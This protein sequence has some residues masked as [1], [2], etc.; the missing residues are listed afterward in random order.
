MYENFEQGTPG[1]SV[2]NITGWDSGLPEF[3]ITDTN[4]CNGDQSIRVLSPTGGVTF[5][6][7]PSQVVELG[8]AI[9]ISF[10]YKLIDMATG[11]LSSGNI[12]NIE[13]QYSVNG[14]QNWNV[15]DVIDQNDLP[16]SNCSVHTSTIPASALAPGD[17][18]SWRLRA[19]D[20]NTTSG[21]E[22][23]IYVDDF[24]AIED[25][26]CLKPINIEV[27]P[28]SVSFTSLDI[29]WVDLNSP[30][31]SE[32][33]VV[34]CTG[35][36][37]PGDSV[38]NGNPFCYSLGGGSDI[39]TVN[40]TPDPATNRMTATIPGLA[41]G[42]TYYIYVRTVCGPN[43]K[44]NWNNLDTPLQ[45]QTLAIGSYCEESIIINQDPLNPDNSVDLP[46]TSIDQ[47]DRF[48][49][50][51][52]SST[53]GAACGTNAPVLDGYEVVYNMVSSEDDI[54]TIDV[55]GLDSN[56]TAGVFVYDSCDDIGGSDGI[57]LYGDS[58]SDGSD[59]QLNSVFVDA[60]Q[61]IY[62]VIAT[63]DNTGGNPVNS[64][65]ELH[66][67]GFDCNTWGAPAGDSVIP[68]VGSANQTLSDF[69]NSIR[70]V[71]P[72]PHKG[73]S[74]SLQWYPDS[75][76][77]PDFS[78]P[79]SD[80]SSIIINDQDVF[81]VTQNI[82]SCES[83]P[84]AVTFDEITCNA[85][86]GGLSSPQGDEVCG[87]GSM[88]LS[89]VK[90]SSS[91]DNYSEV[92]WYNAASGGQRLGVGETFDT[93]PI[94]ETTSYWATEVFLGAG[95][96]PNQGIIGPV[97]SSSSSSDFGLSI[98]AIEPFT[99]SSVDVYALGSGNLVLE[100]VDESSSQLTLTK[101][102]TLNGGSSSVPVL[103][104]IN[105]DWEFQNA[106]DYYLRKVS[107][108]T[109]LYTSSSNANFPY[110]LGSSASITGGAN[111]SGGNS[112][113]YYYFYNWTIKGT[114][115]LCERTPRTEVEAIVHEI[116][117]I[118]ITAVEDIVCVGSMAEL[119]ASSTDTDYQYTW[120]WN[121]NTNHSETGTTITPTI[122]GNTTFTV[123]GYNPITTC[124]TTASFDIIANGV[125]DLGVIPVSTDV[126]SDDI[127]RLTAGSEIFDFEDGS[128][129]W[130]TENNSM[131]NI[132]NSSSADWE[133]VNSPFSPEGSPAVNLS[134][135][136]NSKYYISV[137]DQLGSGASLD[138]RLISPTVNLVGVASFDLNFE[139]FF[140]NYSYLS[141]T[142]TAINVEVSL[143]QGDNWESVATY[144]FDQLDPAGPFE[145]E[146]ISLD[147]YVGL[148]NVLISFHYTGTWGWWMAVDN[149]VFKRQFVE[150]FVTWSP[151]SD[152]YFDDQATIPYDGS[153]VNE[154]YFTQS[155]DGDYTYTALL[156]FDTCPNVSSNVDISV[157]YTDIPTTSS[158][159]Q[160]Y[161]SGDVVDD[162]DVT[163]TNLKFYLL[164][165]NG[166]YDLVTIN[167]LLSHGQ[168]YYVT[169][170]LN[171]CESDFLP[172]TVELDCPQ[173]TNLT[174]VDT[175]LSLDEDSA[176]IVIEWDEPAN[177]RSIQ[178]YIIEI[179]DDSSGQEVYSGIIE[180]GTNFEVINDLPIN[181]DLT[182]SMY[183]L[184]DPTIP[185]ESNVEVLNFDTKDLSVDN[186]KIFNKLVCYPNP[187][188]D[189]IYFENEFAI[190]VIEIYSLAGQ[191]ILTKKVGM[192][193]VMLS[194]ES[195]S[196]GVYF[197][198][199]YVK[200]TKQIIKIIK[201]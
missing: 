55:T 29:S 142:D 136:D 150:G 95:T 172:I 109:L 80:P 99:L 11:S 105:L 154:V 35:P 155:E 57:C 160:S 139:Y 134:S 87:S 190:D 198:S 114:Q 165:Q 183:S 149:V 117:P 152:L 94:S 50:E 76:G 34:A 135:N 179:T 16:T 129:G 54:L 40:G 166:E 103:T 137:A 13:L 44:S 187:T 86:L 64:P 197:A 182:L 65:Y 112:S 83:T 123:E 107:G 156:N 126:C 143:D 122:L 20:L 58:T 189:N 176:S 193:K 15:Y 47:T 97:T 61:E 108:P 8:N 59:I 27:D 157:S 67:E 173:P 201:E 110:S 77:S 164:D 69:T 78:N 46:Y 180:G 26:G 38:N 158:S 175:G 191:K 127:V 66:I 184:C 84:L 52:Y 36:G 188:K 128:Q 75:G 96:V 167:Y 138:T 19:Q 24:T 124:S 186:N 115:V 14:G 43:D 151:T 162:L 92:Y 116:Q 10:T 62:I 200:N 140:R 5:V 1:I 51:D 53:P 85:D 174:I 90:N 60:G 28:S 100:L 125:G 82:G 7:S 111:A 39:I 185:V 17:N 48:G 178:D 144:D 72:S 42:T 195:F 32:W 41:D 119:T 171:G 89:V 79:I 9:E 74:I 104:T 113:N 169:Q 33:E 118:T 177:V 147:E 30:N 102:V 31:A 37:N 45:V 12:V 98:S 130:T 192:D 56:I 181:A 68:F 91:F 170:T 18:F 141:N 168:T 199:V 196:S 22:F 23:Y 49:F 73:P 2:T 120:T 6:E 153:P 121:D 146:S 163:G 25:V 145:T 63:I 106:G 21:N 131:S 148:S 159:T 71:S 132:G 133:I 3:L 81:Y 4:P 161:V 88:E 70:G 194:M 93:P 101:T